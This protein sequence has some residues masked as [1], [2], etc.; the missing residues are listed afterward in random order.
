MPEGGLPPQW[1]DHDDRPVDRPP[2]PGP[3][4][5]A[6][7]V[8][9][10]E[11]QGAD[12]DRNAFTMGTTAEA[13]A[14][15]DRLGITTGE[16]ILDVGCGTGRHL[17]HIAG[18]TGITGVGVDVSPTLVEVANGFGVPGCRFAV[19][20][21]RALTDVPGVTDGAPYDIAWTL[22]QG[23][24]GT[25][26]VTDRLVVESMAS[27]VR[28]GGTVVVTAFHALFAARHLVEEDA[29]DV[30]HGVHHQATEVRGPEHARRTFDLWTTAYTVG[31]VVRLCRD[32]GLVVDAVAGCEPGRYD[33]TEVR[34]D[35][36]ELLA[37]CRRPMT[38]DVG[39]RT[40]RT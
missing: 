23:A 39:P 38:D 29:Y 4:V 36:P 2:P 13:A 19:G 8:P 34:L 24:F 26:P 12:Y 11:F 1:R 28:P 30:V 15:V 32:A 22:C 10:M 33:A 25:H 3:D 7:Y 14:L 37:V 21:A 16:R 31:E 6:F 9:L 40:V 27:V 18:T 17:R 20:D 5:E 35:D